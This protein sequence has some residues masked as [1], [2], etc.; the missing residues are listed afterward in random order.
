M[1]EIRQVLSVVA[2]LALLGFS[3]WWL[4]G[5]GVA[6]F[7]LRNRGAGKA[8]SMQ[9]VERLALTPHHSLHLVRVG[10]RTILVAASPG[11]CSLL[12]AMPEVDKERTSFS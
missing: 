4:R 5:K 3:L 9:V 1:E 11:G 12:D 6:H 2:V 10:E 7:A 8:R